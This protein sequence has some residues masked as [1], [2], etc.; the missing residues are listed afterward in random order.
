ME[1]KDAKRVQTKAKGTPK[2]PQREPK[3]AQRDPKGSQREPKGSQMVSKMH[4]KVDQ[5]SISEKGRQ[6]VAKII[7]TTTPLVGSRFQE[8]T[9]PIHPAPP[10]LS[11]STRNENEPAKQT[12]QRSKNNQRSK[13]TSNAN[14]PAMQTNQQCK[15]TSNVNQ[16]A[17]QTNQQHKPTSNAN[18]PA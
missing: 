14:Q 13:P 10:T 4:P 8:P 9:R 12:N 1:P 7:P 3:G 16:P 6:K 15:P 18:Q 5:I 2:G 17:L 11:L